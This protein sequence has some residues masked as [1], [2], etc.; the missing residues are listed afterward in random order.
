[1]E[2]AGIRVP[3]V[4]ILLRPEYSS[5]ASFDSI[6]NDLALADVG[7]VQVFVCFG[8]SNVSASGVDSMSAPRCGSQ[9]F[10][11]QQVGQEELRRCR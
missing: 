10:Q 5:T 8:S 7:V 1:M 6:G 9:R 3:T 11:H 4:P 2:L